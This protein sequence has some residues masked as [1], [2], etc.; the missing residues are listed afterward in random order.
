[1]RRLSVNSATPF[2]LAYNGK[3]IAECPRAKSNWKT[4]SQTFNELDVAH[5]WNIKPSEYFNA[6][7]EDKLYMT[8]YALSKYEM[9]AVEEY[10]N[11]PKPGRK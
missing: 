11:R 10:A 5:F 1:M 2:E 6:S 3:P 8:A 9:Q 7:T 4:A